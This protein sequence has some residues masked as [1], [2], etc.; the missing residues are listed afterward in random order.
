MMAIQYILGQLN[1]PV[2][3]LLGFIQGWQ[4]AK[5]SMERLNEI[6]EMEDEEP[7]GKTFL[8]ELPPSK[9]IQ[10]QNLTFQYPGAGNEPV[11]KDI[12]LIIPEGKT[13]AIVGMSGSGKLCC[14]SFC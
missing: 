11:L 14:S 4:D 8:K 3:Q 7:N 6:H 10:L 1:S 12:D 9:T 2:E 13:T 5:I